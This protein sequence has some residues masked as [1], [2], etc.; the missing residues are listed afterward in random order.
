MN[1]TIAFLETLGSRADLE[2]TAALRAAAENAELSADLIEA[3]AS[4]DR[5]QIEAL[6]GART[7]LVCAVFP[8]QPDGDQP[9]QDAPPDEP[10]QEP[11]EDQRG[12]AIAA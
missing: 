11:A 5:G 10:A 6:L 3:L 4:R 12:A 2:E 8:V 9:D 7:N 1:R